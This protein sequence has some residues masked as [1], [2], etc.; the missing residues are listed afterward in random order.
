MIK[1][2]TVLNELSLQDYCKIFDKDWD[3][4]EALLDTPY[5]LTEKYIIENAKLTGL[6]DASI[7][8]IVKTAKKVNVS[9]MLKRL[10]I[11]AHYLLF[12][13]LDS[14][15][16]IAI[17]FPDMQNVLNDEGFTYNLLLTLSG[18]DISKKY[19]K[20]LGIPADVA[21][22]A[23]KDISLWVSH[24]RNNFGY[25]GLNPEMLNWER[26]L[27][28]GTLFRLGRLQFNI[29]PFTGNILVFKNKKTNQV[30]ALVKKG[31]DI[32]SLGL[33]DG[34][35]EIFDKEAWKS[36]MLRDKQQVSGNPVTPQGNVLH[37]TIC[38]KFSE[39]DEVL[40]PKDPILEIHIP[41]GESL[42]IQN[43]VNS[44]NYSI[45]FF[46][47]YFP[48]KTY[49]G[50]ACYSWLLDNQYEKILPKSAN[51][52]KFMQEFYLFPIDA[53]GEDS[54]KRIFGENGIKNG[55]INAPR[56]SSM[57][58]S[59]AEFIENGGK[60]RAGGGFFLKNDLPWGKQV[61][62]QFKLL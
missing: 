9:P 20:N 16:D 61:Y 56:K 52:L 32:N 25:I 3:K 54:Y 39:W 49:K 15:D 38:L 10:F 12:I 42:N 22:G 18:M 23:F 41:A 59:V 4:S 40:V 51:I 5:F 47:K 24:F 44:I 11:H 58:R 53:S 55:I 13:C 29:R 8:S 46:A 21:S 19:F 50:W 45:K 26:G 43:C 62:R 6:D 34:V 57:Q 7:A 35:N 27:M 28:R 48:E 2:N 17:N 14:P 30:Q 60:L 33:F 1:L 37:K 36:D 31:I